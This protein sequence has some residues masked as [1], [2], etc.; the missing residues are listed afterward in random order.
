VPVMLVRVPHQ[1]WMK[2]AQLVGGSFV[3]I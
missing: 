2:M 1:D 3:P